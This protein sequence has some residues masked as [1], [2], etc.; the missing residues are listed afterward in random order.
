MYVVGLGHEGL[1]LQSQD[2][3]GV[4]I[5]VLAVP[6]LVPSVDNGMPVVEY[7]NLPFILHDSAGCL[8]SLYLVLCS[9]VSV[10]TSE[11]VMTI[12]I[13]FHLRTPI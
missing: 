8:L 5:I 6:G 12:G 9:E 1:F 2:S 4:P 13:Y 11:T 10:W 7:H 3:L